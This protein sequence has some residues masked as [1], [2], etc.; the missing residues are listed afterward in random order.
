MIASSS[1]EQSMN[2]S[3]ES[4]LRSD[5]CKQCALIFSVHLMKEVIV[6]GEL[7]LVGG[8]GPPTVRCT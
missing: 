5:T 3:V 6:L 4:S 1:L 2:R 8:V 7:G